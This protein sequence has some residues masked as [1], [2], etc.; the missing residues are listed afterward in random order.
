MKPN[1]L[2]PFPIDRDSNNHCGTGLTSIHVL[3][4]KMKMPRRACF[5][6]GLTCDRD[7]LGSATALGTHHKDLNHSGLQVRDRIAVT[8]Y[9]RT[10]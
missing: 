2:L 1:A 8:P 6:R 7:V 10:V 5:L 3:V 4:D 9:E